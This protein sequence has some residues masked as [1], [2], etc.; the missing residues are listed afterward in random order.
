MKIVSHKGTFYRKVA[1]E[2]AKIE[3]AASDLGKVRELIRGA[4]SLL[5]DK[6]YKECE[7]MLDKQIADLQDAK[8][9]VKEDLR[10]APAA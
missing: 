6:K 3:D 10:G 2:D 7:D 4:L 5:R 1:D 9:D 8:Q